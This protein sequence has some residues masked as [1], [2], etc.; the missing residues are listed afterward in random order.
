MIFCVVKK[1][2][3]ERIWVKEHR[4]L[5]PRKLFNVVYADGGMH[6]VFPSL[7]SAMLYWKFFFFLL[8]PQSRQHVDSSMT[9]RMN[10]FEELRRRCRFCRLNLPCA[11]GKMQGMEMFILSI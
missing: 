8:T 3:A 9:M 5:A 1:I 11:I 2:A 6:A 10:Y 7:Y 4:L